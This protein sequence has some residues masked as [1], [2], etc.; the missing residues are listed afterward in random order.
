MD[1]CR[2][3]L[4]V[5]IERTESTRSM[6]THLADAIEHGPSQSRGETYQ[7]DAIEALEHGAE[8]AGQKVA[9]LKHCAAIY[10]KLVEQPVPGPGR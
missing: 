6:L 1:P 2:Q 8:L 10:D 9:N 3:H 4:D 5:E 7:T